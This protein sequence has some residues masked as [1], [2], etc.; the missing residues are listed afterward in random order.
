MLRKVAW[1]VKSGESEEWREGAQGAKEN[2]EW[3]AVRCQKVSQRLAGWREQQQ[4]DL[5]EWLGDQSR[6]A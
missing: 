6:R 1:S 2:D 3:G 4:V 5:I